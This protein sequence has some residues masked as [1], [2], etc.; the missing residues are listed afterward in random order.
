VKYNL[1]NTLADSSTECAVS[2]RRSRTA[3]LLESDLLFSSAQ[4]GA[5]ARAFTFLEP[6]ADL[7]SVEAGFDNYRQTVLQMRP[8]G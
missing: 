6:P 4:C 1:G 5:L 2:V 7:A 8:S 3:V